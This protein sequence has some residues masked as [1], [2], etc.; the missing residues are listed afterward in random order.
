VK[1][2]IKMT[3]EEETQ[4]PINERIATVLNIDTNADPL[5]KNRIDELLKMVEEKDDSPDYQFERDH[6]VPG[7]ETYMR[8]RL[9]PRM[10]SKRLPEGGTKWEFGIM[11]ITTG[12]HN[13]IKP[14]INELNR[15]A[16]ELQSILD[17]PCVV[18]P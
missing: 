3:Q 1:L 16:S 4:F 5:E 11:V 18:N 6:S 15:I 13:N 2:K 10:Q 14:E 12:D 9:L 8:P 17:V 7:S